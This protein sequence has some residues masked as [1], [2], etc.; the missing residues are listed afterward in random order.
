MSKDS[1]KASRDGAKI[2]IVDDD[3]LNRDL[4]K[5]YVL[6]LGHKPL[7]AENGLS[8]LAMMRRNAP[9]AVL[10]DIIMPEMDGYTVLKEMKNDADLRDIPVIVI[11]GVDEMD[12]IVRCIERGADDYLVKPFNAT[13][14]RAR[15][16]SCLDRKRLLDREKNYLRQIEEYN[17]KLEARVK[18]EVQKATAAQMA[19]VFALAKLAEYRD[20][21]TGKHL[22]RIREY[23]RVLAE[24]LG[25]Y[26][27]CAG[28][29]DRPFVEN[30]YFASPLHDIG[31]VGIPEHIL[32]KPGRLTERE[33]EIMKTHTTIGA[34]TLRSVERLCPGHRFVHMGIVIAQSH[35]EKW[36]GTGYPQCLAGRTIP[37]PARIVALAD[38]YDALTSERPYRGAAFSHE[39]AKEII[40]AGSGRHFDPDVVNAF[41]RAESRFEEI[42]KRFADEKG[43][44]AI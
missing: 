1:D 30:I 5:E 18:R 25:K 26:P 8:A 22:E 15:L 32:K 10:L 29:I 23:C 12:S 11:S 6:S 42:K 43:N 35:H 19:T 13:L 41:L 28:V 39:K 4:L 21:Q 9:D 40:V 36:D 2:L 33:F 14:L 37:L 27:R 34:E 24:E 31:K 17:L 3:A 7:L 38:V 20:L 16:K 44:V